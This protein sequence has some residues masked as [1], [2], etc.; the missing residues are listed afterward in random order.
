MNRHRHKVPK[1]MNWTNWG[2]G[3][4]IPRRGSHSGKKPEGLMLLE[5]LFFWIIKKSGIRIGSIGWNFHVV[6]FGLLLV[7]QTFEEHCCPHTP[8]LCLKVSFL[9]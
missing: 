9:Y 4:G 5:F 2:F 3:G 1:Q 6:I 8:S 7:C